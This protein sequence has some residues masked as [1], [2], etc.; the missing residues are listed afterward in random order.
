MAWYCCVAHLDLLFLY[1][2]LKFS[3]LAAS[4][5][6]GFFSSPVLLFFCSSFPPSLL[7][8]KVSIRCAVF[9]LT[10][11]LLSLHSYVSLCFSGLIQVILFWQV[12]HFDFLLQYFILLR[13]RLP[14]QISKVIFH[15][16][17]RWEHLLL[18]IIIYYLSQIYMH[19][20][21]LLL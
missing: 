20:F 4:D 2:V 19:I 21:L 5:Q 10:L 18:F 14:L 11:F 9:I 12:V 15:I 1:P 8:S 6:S 17:S 7:L 13:R 16:I 3:P